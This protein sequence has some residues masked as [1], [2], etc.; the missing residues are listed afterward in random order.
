MTNQTN[1]AESLYE[2]ITAHE[3]HTQTVSQPIRPINKIAADIEKY[4]PRVPNSAEVYLNAMF[5]L[6]DKNSK[7][8]F[9]KAPDII[10]RFLCNATAWKGQH[11]RE[12]KAELK[13]AIK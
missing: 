1:C 2:S 4:W 12:L 10:N 7:F 13:R 6:T 3:F 11:A 9:D 5:A 8:G